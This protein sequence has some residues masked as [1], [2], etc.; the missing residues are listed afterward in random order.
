MRWLIS[1][2]IYFKHGCHIQWETNDM[3]KMTHIKLKP[4]YELNSL[5]YRLFNSIIQISNIEYSQQLN[6]F[7]NKIKK[8]KRQ[9]I[10]ITLIINWKKNNRVFYQLLLRTWFPYP[11]E[12][13]KSPD[14]WFWQEWFFKSK[15]SIGSSIMKN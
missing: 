13:P 10:K 4:E 1:K 12:N 7:W 15:L 3:D 5:K 2:D 9:I 6:Q 8:R 14:D 11:P